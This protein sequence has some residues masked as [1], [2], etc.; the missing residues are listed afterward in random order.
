MEHKAAEIAVTDIQ[1]KKDK[2]SL[3]K[4]TADSFVQI[5]SE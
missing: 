3:P 1:A 4:I 5:N 2:M